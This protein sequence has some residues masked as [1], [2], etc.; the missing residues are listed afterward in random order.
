MCVSRVDFWRWHEI[1]RSSEW[2]VEGGWICGTYMD[3]DCELG[4]R[5]GMNRLARGKGEWIFSAGGWGL[6]VEDFCGP[7]FGGG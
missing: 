4:L 2:I 5:C 1:G 3:V 6:N 7:V